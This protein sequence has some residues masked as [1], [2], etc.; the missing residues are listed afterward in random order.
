MRLNASKELE[1]DIV[2]LALDPVSGGHQL[3]H[4]LVLD[5]QSVTYRY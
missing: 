1:D 3:S 5:G 2:G 4:V